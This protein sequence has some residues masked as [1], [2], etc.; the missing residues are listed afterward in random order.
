MKILYQDLYRGNRFVAKTILE[1][2]GHEVD[3]VGT[4]EDLEKQVLDIYGAIIIDGDSFVLPDRTN[5]TLGEYLKNNVNGYQGKIIISTTQPLSY[6]KEILS[7]YS[8]EVHFR[9]KP[10]N[11]PDVGHSLNREDE[12]SYKI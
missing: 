7:D 3:S 2:C 10:I 8:G 6:L 11:L 5:T 12:E 1:R 4:K 9:H